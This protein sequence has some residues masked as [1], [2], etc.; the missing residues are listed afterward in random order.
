MAEQRSERMD[1]D[2]ATGGDAK[3]DYEKHGYSEQS[4]KMLESEEGQ[5]NAVF[6][7]YGSAARHGQLFEDSLSKL[8]GLPNGLK[9]VDDPD[10]G[11]DKK[12]IG[13]LLRLFRTKFVEKIDDWVPEFLDEARQRRNFLIHEYF[14]RRSD[15]MG[16]AGG[17][18]AILRE[19]IGI[20]AHLRRGTELVNG[21]RVAIGEAQERQRNEGGDGETV[22][23]GKLSI[24]GGED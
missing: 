23:S 5:F 21:L 11:L 9:G 6:A 22:F 12:T 20:E 18:F 15:E 19:L 3:L 7:C 8:L 13:Q 17:R 24:G 10:A 2:H 1:G 4:L 16:G 14:L